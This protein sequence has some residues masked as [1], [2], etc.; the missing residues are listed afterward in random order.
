MGE[1]MAG[2]RHFGGGRTRR[3]ARWLAAALLVPA[4]A[5]C[6][7]GSGNNGQNGN[8]QT[9]G[10]EP[11]DQRTE[12]R[13]TEASFQEAG[14]VSAAGRGWGTRAVVTLKSSSPTPVQAVVS[15]VT[16]CAAGAA[17]ATPSQATTT[18][19]AGHSEPLVF[20]LPTTSP[21]GRPICYTV[22][23]GGESRELKAVGG[24]LGTTSPS[25]TAPMTGETGP[26][27]EPTGPGG[28][29]GTE[30]GSTH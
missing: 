27:T 11:S 12:V 29:T 25:P 16:D 15:D 22:T 28:G 8:G 9:A 26:G 2:T 3:A 17:P 7:G 14:A 30:S 4:L 24:V 23:I 6:G 20:A 10:P 21:K 18:V 5:S 19:Y 13:E 1:R